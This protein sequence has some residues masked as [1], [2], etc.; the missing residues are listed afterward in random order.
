M[1]MVVTVWHAASSES[2]ATE[3]GTN[4][5]RM[6]STFLI[7]CCCIETCQ[8][9]DRGAAAIIPFRNTAERFGAVAQ[10]LHWLI[11]LLV[12]GQ[13]VVGTT[14]AD[15]PVGIERLKLLTLHKSL[16]VTTF[17]LVLARLAWRAYSPAPPLPTG[18]PAWQKRAAN[19]SHVLLYGLLLVLPILGWISS[20]ASN[21]TVRWFFLVN[22]PNVTGPD[23]A[24][25]TLTKHLHETG[26]WCLLALVCLHAGAAFWH[27]LVLKDGVLRRM[28]PLPYQE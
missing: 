21:L 20:S 12:I 26:A 10:T 19:A 7:P 24:L 15:L 25:A 2:V 5:L 18:M 28:L 23:P 8:S 1:S 16:G 13:F 22:L 4:S 11:L 17:A 3:R 9:S 6:P 27:E 14:A